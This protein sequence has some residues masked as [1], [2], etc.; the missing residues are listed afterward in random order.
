M[1]IDIVGNPNFK[2]KLKWYYKIVCIVF[3][4]LR[5]L[6]GGK[7]RTDPNRSKRKVLYKVFI[8]TSFVGN[9]SKLFTDMQSNTTCLSSLFTLSSTHTKKIKIHLKNTL[10]STFFRLRTHVEDRGSC[11]GFLGTVVGE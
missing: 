4:L 2:N 6:R 10:K 11:H 1:I 7:K 3:H 5:T 8:T 9:Q